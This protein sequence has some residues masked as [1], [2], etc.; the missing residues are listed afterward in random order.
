LHNDKNSTANIAVTILATIGIAAISN[1]A[2]AQQCSQNITKTQQSADYVQTSYANTIL[3]KKSGYEWQRCSQ[4]QTWTNGNCTGEAKRLTFD[5]AISTARSDNS[6]GG[7]WR[8]PTQTE[9]LTIIESAC[10]N[11]A[12]NSE[13]FPA[14]ATQPY[15]TSAPYAGSVIYAWSVNFNDGGVSYGDKATANYVRLV[16]GIGNTKSR[17]Q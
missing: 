4:G 13:I 7:G 6:N 12:V 16:R 1:T 14:T 3:H 9:L 15:W 8:V 10:T 11:P 17:P 2:L 5:N